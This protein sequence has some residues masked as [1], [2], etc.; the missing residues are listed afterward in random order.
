MVRSRRGDTDG[1]ECRTVVLGAR[2]R[3]SQR[4]AVI[5]PVAQVA[6]TPRGRLLSP[7]RLREAYGTTLMRFSTAMTPGAAQ[8]ARCASSLSVHEF[9]A[10]V[11]TT[12]APWAST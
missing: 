10:P 5:K 8:A 3:V 9:T 11:R 1:A 7:W 6:S 2:D 4:L 12:R